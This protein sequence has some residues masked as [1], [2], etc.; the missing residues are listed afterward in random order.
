MLLCKFHRFPLLPPPP[1]P[2]LLKPAEE[3]SL[4]SFSER[5]W[6]YCIAHRWKAGKVAS[7][8][9]LGH[10]LFHRPLTLALNVSN[11]LDYLTISLY[12]FTVGAIFGPDTLSA[13]KASTVWES[14]LAPSSCYAKLADSVVMDWF[15]VEGNTTE[16]AFPEKVRSTCLISIHC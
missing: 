9:K 7:A 14:D 15:F 4:S 10:G 6:H 5:S 11:C 3:I 1:H 2:A 13:D 12:V 16:F 8:E